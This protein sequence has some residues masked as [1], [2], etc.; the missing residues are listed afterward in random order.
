M[1]EYIK[2]MIFVI[3]YFI[4]IY[5]FGNAIVK[6]KCKENKVLRF[7]V[8]Y[9]AFAFFVA[10]GGIPMQMFQISWSY[11]AIY[12]GVVIVGVLV[13]SIYAIRK[14]AIH[15]FDGDFKLF[16]RNHWFMFVLSFLLVA[17]SAL[18]FEWYWLNNGLD[19]GYYLTRIAA[20]PYDGKLLSISASTGLRMNN[21]L[22]NSYNLNVFDLEA[23]VYV[24]A[25]KLNPVIFGRVFLAYINYFLFGCVINLLFSKII[26]LTD[27]KISK[28]IFQFVPIIIVMFS[29]SFDF[30][31][32][33]NLHHLQDAWQNTTAMYYGSS[34]VRNMGIPLL[35]IPLIGKKKIE[36]RDLLIYAI[37][38]VVLLSKSTITI[39]FALITAIA[40]LIVFLIRQKK[41]KELI[42]L[43]LALVAINIV[44][45]NN[46]NISEKYYLIF[47][48]NMK[49]III[50]ISIIVLFGM[51]FI[52]KKIIHE[53]LGIIV[54]LIGLTSIEPINNIFEK[55]AIYDFVACRY[56]TGIFV[57]I[58]IIAFIGIIICAYGIVARKIDFL[59][60]SLI[61]LSFLILFSGIGLLSRVDGNVSRLKSDMMLFIENPYFLPTSVK[62][63][64]D[65]LTTLSDTLGKKLNVITPEGIQVDDRTYALAVSLRQVAP[66][67]VSISA[68]ER[69]MSNNDADFEDYQIEYQKDFD[70]LLTNPNYNTAM[71]MKKVFDNYPINCIVT[72]NVSLD[73]YIELLGFEKY[74]VISYQNNYNIYYR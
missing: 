8:G 17:M 5:S 49:S 30:M 11:F 2:G 48:S 69:Y 37:T 56:M 22:A 41:Y 71:Q 35:L 16:L 72:A 25:F 59:P 52:K 54:T 7:V 3:L 55:A 24:F 20:L 34:I 43:S 57:F 63:L 18:C 70:R 28:Y 60:V 62:M 38:S 44:I 4:F 51:L 36:F 32:N 40:Y 9:I 26:S 14:N 10:I 1:I 47:I 73:K 64:G 29:F 61:N 15:L 23:S 27:I 58:I 66:S 68:L 19:D 67:V 46:A 50:I 42:I 45:G 33:Y 12:L 65:E 39:P 13:Y 21:S 6:N 31:N 74:K 53:L